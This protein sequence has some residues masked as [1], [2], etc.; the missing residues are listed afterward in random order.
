MRRVIIE[1]TNTS[2]E[3]RRLVS[4]AYTGAPPVLSTLNLLHIESDVAGCE[5][6]VLHSVAGNRHR[7][8]RIHTDPSMRR[9]A[10]SHLHTHTH[11]IPKMKKRNYSA[12]E[13]SLFDERQARQASA[14]VCYLR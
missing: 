11:A 10:Y 14:A 9:D 8:I 12:W 4:H 2:T 5:F 7:A 3:C 1:H 6:R 13:P